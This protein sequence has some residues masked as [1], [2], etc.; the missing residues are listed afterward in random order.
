M[1]KKILSLGLLL[2]IWTVLAFHIQNEIILPN[3]L[4]VASQLVVL[5]QNGHFYLSIGVTF[6]RAHIAFGLSLILGLGLAFLSF[7]LPSLADI[8]SPWIK[9]LQS[10]P[11]ISFI[12]LLLFWFNNE[13]SI[14]WVVFL[15]VF[16]IAYFNILEALKAIESDYL[17]IIQISHQPWYYNLQKAYLPLASSGVLA[18]IKSGLP[19]ALKITVMSEVLIHTQTG[20]GR[21]LSMARADIDMISVFAWT[22]VLVF[23]VSLEVK[24]ITY[25]LEKKQRY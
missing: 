7:K 3:P 16:P 2:G 4:D 11:Q 5:F 23:L 24:L 20:I 17:D 13:Q 25:L 6:L 12:I 18:T 1:N 14:L 15:M 22:F 10:I 21:A 8:F 19:I 9:F